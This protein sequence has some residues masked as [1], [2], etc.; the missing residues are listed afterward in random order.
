MIYYIIFP[1]NILSGI[2]QAE[3][4]TWNHIATHR[5]SGDFLVMVSAVDSQEFEKECV[6][7]DSDKAFLQVSEELPADY[8]THWFQVFEPTQN[9]SEVQERFT[10]SSDNFFG[11]ESQ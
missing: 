10:V 2:T 8:Q 7:K 9:I 3:T 11:V 1:K 4:V 5:V 6:L